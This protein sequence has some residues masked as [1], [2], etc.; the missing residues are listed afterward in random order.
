MALMKGVYK[1]AEGK[2]HIVDLKLSAD[3]GIEV[4]GVT[5]DATGLGSLQIA[6]STDEGELHINPDGSVN[7]SNYT[8]KESFTTATNNKLTAGG[9]RYAF[10]IWNQGS[11]NL[12]FTINGITVTVAPNATYNNE[13]DAFT[14]VT[15]SS[16]AVF[17][18]H[19]LGVRT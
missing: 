1:D 8:V 4:T 13:F 10:E 12:T 7:V 5:L 14:E 19:L 2:E 16:G 17:E 9:T 18:A 6:G 3:G 11:S 15:L